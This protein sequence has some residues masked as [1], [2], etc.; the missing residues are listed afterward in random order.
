MFCWLPWRKCFHSNWE[1]GCR[2]RVVILLRVLS[3][4]ALRQPQ[5]I[6]PSPLAPSFP[7]LSSGVHC[8]EP[9]L[10]PVWIPQCALWGPGCSPTHTC[11]LR[12]NPLCSGA[13][14]RGWPAFRSLDSQKRCTHPPKCAG[15]WVGNSTF[16]TT[17]MKAEEDP[18]GP[19]QARAS[20]CW[21]C[22]SSSRLRTGWKQSTLTSLRGGPTPFL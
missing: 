7:S 2:F 14:L 6:P 11:F 22:S 13:A 1:L 15:H 3:Q 9:L 4:L 20:L 18:N 10:T 19:L 17:E 16:L 5:A 8:K 12:V 21:D